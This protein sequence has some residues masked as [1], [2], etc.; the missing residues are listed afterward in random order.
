MVI[1]IDIFRVLGWVFY[2]LSY[3]IYNIQVFVKVDKTTRKRARG[4]REGRS[5]N[6][7]LAFQNKGGLLF[8]VRFFMSRTHGRGGVHGQIVKLIHDSICLLELRY[9]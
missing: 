4:K 1:S 3:I 2:C 7:V 9:L 5:R 6:N 8:V